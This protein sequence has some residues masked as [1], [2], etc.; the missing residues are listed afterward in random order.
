MYPQHHEYI[1]SKAGNLNIFQSGKT[2]AFDSSSPTDEHNIE[3]DFL[4]SRIQNYELDA[5]H[6]R[7]EEGGGIPEVI[8]DMLKAIFFFP[9]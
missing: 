7:G 3:I 6:L 5:R 2:K 8:V 1:I 4:P 9:Y